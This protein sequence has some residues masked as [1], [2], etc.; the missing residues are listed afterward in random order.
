MTR[1]MRVA[2]AQYPIEQLTSVGAFEEKLTRWVEDAASNGAQLIVFPEYAA[3]EW[4]RIA[5]RVASS[6]LLHSLHALQFYLGA[7]CDVHERLAKACN[8]TI[9]SG[10]APVLMADHKFVN[11]VRIFTPCGATGFQQK[12][13][14]TRFEREEWGIE[15][16]AGLCVFDI[17][18]T[19]LGVAIC[20][21]VEFPL[22]VRALAEAGAEIVV[23]PSCT[24]TLSGYH[25]VRL[26]C[27]ARALENQIFTVQSSTVGNAPWC[28]ALDTNIG[29]AGFFAPPDTLF[30]AD[31]VIAAGEL[32]KPQWV[33]A[34]LDL[35]LLKQVRQSGEV[36]NYLDWDRQGYIPASKDVSRVDLT[37]KT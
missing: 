25:R 5:G 21:D 16:S 23:V 26:A 31:G 32:N 11:R 34:D 3:L 4:S 13:I 8:V 6:D 2:S 17:G 12:H 18:I 33:Y 20:Y 7:Y 27:A 10:S 30:P 37:H 1:K 15:A 28:A 36:L 29:A 22:L 24:D 19:R 35:D 9:V 14:M